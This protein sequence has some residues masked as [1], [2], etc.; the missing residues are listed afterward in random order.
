RLGACLAVPFLAAGSGPDASVGG[1][2]AV[3]PSTQFLLLFTS[4]S[5]GAPKAVRCSQGRL[6]AIGERAAE[7]YEFERDDICYCAMPLFHGNAIMAVWAPAL[8]VG[9]TFATRP[10]FSA[11]GFLHDVRRFRATFFNYVGKSL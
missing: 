6:A 4:G 3:E 11:S 10:K 9:A 7:L 1:A 2:V 8:S 5:T